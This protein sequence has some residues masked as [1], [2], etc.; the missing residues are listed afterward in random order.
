MNKAVSVRTNRVIAALISAGL[1]AGISVNSAVAAPKNLARSVVQADW[2][3]KNLKKPILASSECIRIKDEDW[4]NRNVLSNYPHIHPFIKDK[5]ACNVGTLAGKGDEF[6]HF[7]LHLYHFIITKA[8][9][10]LL[11]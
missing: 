6:K 1:L 4:N 7:C 3:E 11:I 10:S 2:L 5:E 8:Y 9:V